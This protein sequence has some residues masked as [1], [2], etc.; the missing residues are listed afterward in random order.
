M[1]LTP[2][3]PT[4]AGNTAAPSSRLASAPRFIGGFMLLVGL[5]IVACVATAGVI[6][7]LSSARVIPPDYGL[8]AMLP[9]FAIG[10]LQF[11]YVVPLVLVAWR[12]GLGPFSYGVMACAA[13]TFMLNAS[14]WGLLV[15]STTL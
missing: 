6:L 14:C 9:P 12:R 13:A 1:S 7:G 15:L 5:H 8:M 2:A 4:D 3:T 11:V 10:V